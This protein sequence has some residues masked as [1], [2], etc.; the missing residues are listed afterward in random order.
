MKIKI[1]SQRP[2][3]STHAQT[4][5]HVQTLQHCPKMREVQVGN[6][7]EK[8]QSERE[9]LCKK[10]RWGKIN[11]QS[12]SYTM[13][14]YREPNEQLFPNRWPLSYLNLTICKHT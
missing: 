4:L 1:S 14:S 11:T 9:S 12:G 6:D 13:K 2:A 10:P 5:Q 3:C 7:Q 8:A